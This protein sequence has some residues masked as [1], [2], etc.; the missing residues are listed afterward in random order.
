MSF[1]GGNASLGATSTPAKRFGNV[2]TSSAPSLFGGTATATN[3]AGF[4]GFGTATSTAPAFGGFGNTAA[5]LVLPALVG[6]AQR[7]QQRQLLLLV[8]SVLKVMPL[9]ARYGGSAFAFAKPAV[10][11]L[12]GFGGFSGA[13]NFMLGQPQQAVPQLSPDEALH[14]L[15]SMF[16]FTVMNETQ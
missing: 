6:L 8:D 4:G 2:A 7:Q 14:S 15:S 12:P 3:T 11:M 5:L 16:P 13:T 9:E 10:Q 1:F